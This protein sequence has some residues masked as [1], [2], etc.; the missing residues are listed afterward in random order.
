MELALHVDAGFL[1]SRRFHEI[2]RHRSQTG[3][4]EFVHVRRI[5]ARAEIH[6]LG[7]ILTDDIDH[8][9]ARGFNVH[10]RVLLGPIAAADHGTKTDHRRVRADDGEEAEGRQVAHSVRAQRGNER[11]RTG[12][13]G[14]RQQPVH[15]EGIFGRGIDDHGFRYYS[16]WT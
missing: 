7:E 11:Y 3:D 1:D 16:D 10:Q 8:E 13:N 2:A 5:L 6:F 4:T 14:A 9:F 15:V 12:K